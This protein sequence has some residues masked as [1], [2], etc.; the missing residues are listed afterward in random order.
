MRGDLNDERDGAF[1]IESGLLFNNVGAEKEKVRSPY[2]TEF[3]EGI[4]DERKLRFGWE[5]K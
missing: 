5:D 3:I 4:A 1:L 2:L